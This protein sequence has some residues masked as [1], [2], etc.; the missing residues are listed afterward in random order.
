MADLAAKRLT[1][2]LI[3]GL[4]TPAPEDGGDFYWDTEITGFGLRLYPSGTKVFIYRG[5]V[6]GRQEFVK[7]GDYGDWTPDAARKEAR[8]IAVKFDRGISVNAEK[9]TAR[10]RG[11]TLDD[12]F[13]DYLETHNLRP[14]TAATYQ[15]DVNRLK[16]WLNKPLRDI[17]REMVQARYKKICSDLGT[18]AANKTMR[19]FRAVY[20]F[21]LE[22]SEG[23]IPANP[24]KLK[25]FWR[26]VGKRRKTIIKDADLPAWYKAVNESDNPIVSDCLQL[27]LYTGL[28]I[29]EEA[30]KMEWPDVDMEAR[31]FTITEEKAKGKRENKRYMSRQVHAIFQRRLDNRENGYVFPGASGKGRLG[32]PA[33]QMATITEKT[34]VEFCPHDLRRTFATIANDTVPQ[35]QLKYLLGHSAKGGDV[36]AGYII[37]SAE[38]KMDAEQKMADAIDRL[39][40]PPAEG[41]VIPI[42]TSKRVRRGSK[43]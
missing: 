40:T 26:D 35:S 29:K 34:G 21:A 43:A 4:P 19:V 33:R 36:T 32:Y 27:L 8:A 25:G 3:D 28:R 38:K 41:N 17:G 18:A 37:L 1:K 6:N 14:N 42:G 15:F 12:A 30:L 11:T 20:N 5:R 23:N 22:Q 10:A 31:T 16:D 2:S 9:R 39:L 13:K 7:I 24:V